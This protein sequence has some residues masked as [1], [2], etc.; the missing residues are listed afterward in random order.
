MS[1]RGGGG[2]SS[3]GGAGRAGGGSVSSSS[4]S[5]GGGLSGSGGTKGTSSYS[6]GSKGGRG[7]TRPSYSGNSNGGSGSNRPSYFDGT[8]GGNGRKRPWGGN[9]RDYYRDV[10]YACSYTSAAIPSKNNPFRFLSRRAHEQP[11]GQHQTVLEDAKEPFTAFEDHFLSDLQ[12]A[13]SQNSMKA[14][15]AMP[16][17]H[18]WSICQAPPHENK[19]TKFVCSVASDPVPF[20]LSLVLLF[21]FAAGFYARS[22]QRKQ[23][24]RSKKKAEECA[25][26]ID[27]SQT[28][29]I[30]VM[31]IEYAD[32]SE[33][34]DTEAEDAAG[35][36]TAISDVGMEEPIVEDCEEQHEIP[37]W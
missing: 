14:A 12:S 5:K 10:D 6:G 13:E 26:G 11:R 1:P 37:E 21:L 33:A 17:Y 35:M 16:Q 25:D 4:G 15:Q 3:S 29:D 7:S 34:A 8:N 18:S 32:S 20:F 36:E 23:H 30:K 27:D 28:E 24:E 22:K 9:A 2:G 31:Q 19:C